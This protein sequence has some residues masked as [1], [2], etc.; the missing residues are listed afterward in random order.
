MAATAEKGSGERSNSISGDNNKDDVGGG[1][2][3][4]AS[5]SPTLDKLL[6]NLTSSSPVF[7]VSGLRAGREFVLVVRAAGDEGVSPP[8]VLTAFT[9]TDN[10]QTV[11]GLPTGGGHT[12]G[13]SISS[14]NT[15]SS[16]SSRSKDSTGGEE[17]VWA[18]AGSEGG[19]EAMAS[20]ILGL[21]PPLVLVLGTSL[22][23]LL[24]IALILVLL[25]MKFNARSRQQRQEH[26][27]R[28]GEVTPEDNTAAPQPGSNLG[29][30]ETSESLAEGGSVGDGE[31]GVAEVTTTVAGDNR[32]VG[33]GSETGIE[34]ETMS[35]AV[36]AE[37]HLLSVA[38]DGSLQGAC[39][40]QGGTAAWLSGST[41]TMP[42][43]AVRWAGVDPST[44]GFV[45]G[46]RS[47][48]TSLGTST[49]SICT[50][51]SQCGVGS[52]ADM[53]I[54]RH[55]SR[56][57]SLSGISDLDRGGTAMLSSAHLSD[58]TAA[59]QL[60]LAAAGVGGC[61]SVIGIGDF[62]NVGGMS[63][64]S[65]VGS[66]GVIGVPGRTLT[67]TSGLHSATTHQPLQVMPGAGVAARPHTPQL[68]PGTWNTRL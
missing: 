21:V 33:D 67:D 25:V 32:E 45:R 17:D 66:M 47:I 36:P 63:A 19:V 13:N 40:S 8:V 20:W 61:V 37:R 65:S 6:R 24:L 42:R 38:H 55:A 28:S 9:L 29:G 31:G 51:V 11:I 2:G 4:H 41:A 64:I 48:D 30:D 26:T 23:A 35:Q 16:S 44:R 59:G 52:V 27:K 56:T 53:G 7:L 1:R 57:G 50:G 10:A 15:F 22:I 54:L 58:I 5:V 39:N 18:A 62:P 12:S 46:L 60:G 34:G 43:L 14:I 68:T 49:S 3:G